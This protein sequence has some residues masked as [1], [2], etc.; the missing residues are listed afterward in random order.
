MKRAGM[1]Y[2]I[3][4]GDVYRGEFHVAIKRQIINT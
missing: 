2:L 3:I 4:T 1:A